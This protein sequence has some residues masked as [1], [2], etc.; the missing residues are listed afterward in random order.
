MAQVSNKTRQLVLN[1]QLHLWLVLNVAFALQIGT[2]AFACAM[3]RQQSPMVKCVECERVFTK[4]ATLQSMRSWV[5]SEKC[6]PRSALLC[7]CV[8]DTAFPTCAFWFYVDAQ[9]AICTLQG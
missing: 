7:T 1:I 8:V 9:L 3:S 4:M 6:E 2:P 5:S